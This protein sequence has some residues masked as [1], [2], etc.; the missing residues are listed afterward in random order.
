MIQVAIIEDNIQYSTALCNLVTKHEGYECAG[1][2]DNA[3]TTFLALQ[4]KAFDVA[5]VDVHLGGQTGIELIA[6]LKPLLPHKEFIIHTIFEDSET[7]FDALKAG[8]SGYLLK[9]TAPEKMIEAITDV[10]KGGSP[11]SSNI[12]RKVIASF[13]ESAKQPK[14]QPETLSKRESEILELLAKGYRYKEIADNLSIST[15]TVRT[16]IRNIYQKLQVNSGIE[17][18]NKFFGKK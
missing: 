13:S 4:N 3:E 9:N 12:A 17:A 5:I 6:R 1:V 11:M 8:A 2:F 10:T 14:A 7:I 18:I 16:H 15:E